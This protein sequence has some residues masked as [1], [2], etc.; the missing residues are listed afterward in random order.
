MS[1]EQISDCN[2]NEIVN[3]PNEVERNHDQHYPIKDDSIQSKEII[4]NNSELDKQE[5]NQNEAVVIKENDRCKTD[6]NSS[7]E[8]LKSRENEGDDEVEEKEEEEK[9]KNI[10]LKEISDK[11]DDSEKPSTF[12]IID[13]NLEQ[14]ETTENSSGEKD[15]EHKKK[16][17][18]VKWLKKNVHIHLPKHHSFKKEKTVMEYK[19]ECINSN[20]EPMSDKQI[21]H[22]SS[23]EVKTI[24]H[25]ENEQNVTTEETHETTELLQSTIENTTADHS[26]VTSTTINNAQL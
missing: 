20:E 10:K 13:K 4:V 22:N 9:D 24:E 18:L 17:N 23:E 26:L 1:D 21:N 11:E 7:M 19:T 15:K 5:K 2:T 14:S 3:C 25:T 8:I 16:V 12:E 6:V